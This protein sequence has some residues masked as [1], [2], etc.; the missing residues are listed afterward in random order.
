MNS[1]LAEACNG[2]PISAIFISDGYYIGHNLLS[3]CLAKALE[4][5]STSY[6]VTEN[7]GL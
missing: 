2:H 1:F 5:S 6:V 3:Y 4:N 7:L